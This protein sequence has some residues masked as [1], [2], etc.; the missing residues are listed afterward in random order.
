MQNVQY[1]NGAR[2][3]SNP[4]IKVWKVD[5]SVDYPIIEPANI[6]RQFLDNTYKKTAYN[7]TLLTQANQHGWWFLLP[8]DV[9]VEWDGINKGIEGDSPSHVKIIEGEYFQGLK[10]VTNEIGYGQVA[11][12]FNCNIETDENHY[13]IFSGPP[14]YFYEDAKPLEVIWRSDFFN[15]HQITFHWLITT[16]NKKIVFPKGMPILFIK[17]Y[18]KELLE[19]TDFYIEDLDNNKKLKQDTFDYNIQIADWQKE[20]HLYNYRKFYKNGIGSKYKKMIKNPLSNIKL[21]APKQI[22]GIID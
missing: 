21:K 16:P 13:L 6:K 2:K 14:N 22:N 5:S 12:D 4:Y 7:C 8:Q 19:S 20:H 18:P 17:N 3:M 15:Y 10:I 1:I 9:V 11:F